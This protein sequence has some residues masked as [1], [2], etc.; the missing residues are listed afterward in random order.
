MPPGPRNGGIPLSTESPAPVSATAWRAPAS[1]SPA[2]RISASSAGS[3]AN[4]SC[5]ATSMGAPL[6]EPGPLA[7]ALP[8]VGVH[9]VQALA[10]PVAPPAVRPVIDRECAR[11]V[12][13]AAQHRPAHHKPSEVP[14]VTHVGG[15]E[16]DLGEEQDR[17]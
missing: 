16:V 13:V 8:P 3:K 6:V 5:V 7:V 9:R 12:A 4:S 11:D 1:R 15:A 17:D 14:E 2:R 10:H